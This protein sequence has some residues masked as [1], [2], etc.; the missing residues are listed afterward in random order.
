MKHSV[1]LKCLALSVMTMGG[2]YLWYPLVGVT[3]LFIWSHGVRN[4]L[5]AIFFTFI[6]QLITKKSMLH[7]AWYPG[8]LT[9]YLWLGSFSYILSRSGGVRVESLNDDILTL[10]PVLIIGV[11]FEHFGTQYKRF[12]PFFLI[13][14]MCLLGYFTVSAFVYCAYYFIS[15]TGLTSN[16]MIA[17]L[18]TN[19]REA[20]EFLESHVGVGFTVLAACV[21]LLYLLG[22]GILIA[23]GSPKQPECE[24][25]ASKYMKIAQCVMCLVA[26]VAI[27]HGLPRVFPVHPYQ[28]AHGYIAG[29]QKAMKVH[30]ENLKQFKFISDEIKPIKG[31]VIVIIGES[32]N[33]NHMKAFNPQ[34]PK[35]TTPWLTAKTNE[36]SGFFLFGKTYSNATV[37]EKA[38]SLFLSNL[39][40]YNG[41]KRNDM[42]TLIDVANQ[43]GY[44]TWFI[45]NQTP[46]PGSMALTLSAEAAKHNVVTK[47]PG[48]A[49]M[50]VLDELKR[51]PSKGNHFIIIHL[52]GSHDRYRDRVPQNFDGVTIE[53][54][55]QKV[56]DYD[57]SIKY[58]DEVLKC[59]HQYAKDN[60]NLQ[61]MAYGSDH[62]EDM[63]VFHSDSYF[64]WDMAR[65][66]FFVY[67]APEYEHEYP[68]TAKNLKENQDKIFTNDL[69]FD[70][71]CGLLQAPNNQYD[72][73]FDLSNEHYDLTRNRA[74]TKYG[75]IALSKESEK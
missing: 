11:L 27:R 8:L 55:P 72:S 22:L 65:S 75:Q 7:P 71:V 5:L 10:L 45:S 34:Y 38:L 17:V 68:E 31:S 41:K 48:K 67:L 33:R 23:K 9:F 51:I 57:S 29:A 54:N 39:N 61:V 73:N 6:T 49:D 14:N 1:G 26:V 36:D 37:T 2:L 30:G 20:I 12:R 15:G 21:I 4:I 66:P 74:M 19:F 28:V 60:L 32:A 42:I 40:Q 35:D 52:I 56:N 47:S 44:D 63:E 59:I 18:L 69:V 46:A 70:T 43:I 13:A 24:Y 16:D 25:N 62:G 3:D 58:T 50:Q 53:G 64:T